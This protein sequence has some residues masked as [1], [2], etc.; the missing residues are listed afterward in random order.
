MDTNIDN[1]EVTPLEQDDE[2]DDNT[3]FDAIHPRR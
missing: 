2:E 3:L 1:M